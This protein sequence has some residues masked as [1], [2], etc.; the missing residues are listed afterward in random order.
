MRQTRSDDAWAAL[1]V[2]MEN[3]DSTS[4]TF[5]QLEA[6][7]HDTASAPYIRMTLAQTLIEEKKWDDVLDVLDPLTRSPN[8][9]LALGAQLDVAK[10]YEFQGR[11]Q[12]AQRIYQTLKSMRD[13]PLYAQAASD[14]LEFLK[15][16]VEDIEK[17]PAEGEDEA[18][19][20]EAWEIPVETSSAEVSADN[21]GSVEEV[22][23][24]DEGQESENGAE[25]EVPVGA[26][27]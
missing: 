14:R 23:V 1:R 20:E 27:D 17:S 7:Y 24:E 26:D 11:W 4:D 22:S 6:Q 5:Q 16:Y 9:E 10:V 18:A 13:H 25:R 12:E 8:H 2:A 19:S 15:E 3:P 21:A